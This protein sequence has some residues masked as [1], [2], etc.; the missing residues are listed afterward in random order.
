[1]SMIGSNDTIPEALVNKNIISYE[2][3]NTLM[4][5]MELIYSRGYNT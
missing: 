3:K 2:Q 5:M 4:V 1:M